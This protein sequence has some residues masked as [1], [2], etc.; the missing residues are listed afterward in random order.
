MLVTA[1]SALLYLACF[2]FYHAHK[3]RCGFAQLKSSPRALMALRL[4]GWVLAVLALAFCVAGRGW[5]VG[6]FMWSGCFVLSGTI[7]LFTAALFAK[8]HTPLAG[9]S[10]LLSLVIITL[11]PAQVGL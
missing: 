6:I 8:L 7:S 9:F 1:A 4:G 5:E 3:A 11:A 2:A 10:A